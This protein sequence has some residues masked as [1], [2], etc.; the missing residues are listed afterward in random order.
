[1]VGTFWLAMI[2]AIPEALA[3]LITTIMMLL[4]SSLLLAY[5]SVKVVVTDE[6]LR[7]GRARIRLRHLAAPQELGASGMRTTAGPDA[8][9]RAYLLLRPY[10]LTGVRIEVSDPRDPT[11]YWLVSSR[12]PALLAAALN[13][14]T[15]GVPDAD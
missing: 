10:I 4:L 2:V 13:Q 12:R 8:D 7:A 11:P 6:W 14:G 3:W 1:M 5:G 9:A 15:T